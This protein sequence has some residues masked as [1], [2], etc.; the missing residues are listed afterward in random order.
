MAATDYTVPSWRTDLQNAGKKYGGKLADAFTE[1][2][3]TPIGKIATAAASGPMTAGMTAGVGAIK[4]AYNTL[5]PDPLY[6]GPA[7]YLNGKKPATGTPAP[8]AED[9]LSGQT[10]TGQITQPVEAPK[11][12]ARPDA[13][14]GT[15]QTATPSMPSPIQAQTLAAPAH[16]QVQ[17]PTPG[18]RAPQDVT[19]NVSQSAATP[20]GMMIAGRLAMADINNQKR[21]AKTQFNQNMDVAKTGLQQEANDRQANISTFQ[22]NTSAQNNAAHNN[23]TLAQLAQQ[24]PL[25]QAQAGMYG[26]QAAEAKVKAGQIQQLADL[27]GKYMSE[28]DPAKQQALAKNIAILSGK[29]AEPAPSLHSISYQVGS[30]VDPLTGAET[31]IM[32]NGLYDARTGKMIDPGNAVKPKGPSPSPEHITRLKSSPDKNTKAQFDA[33]FGPGAADKIL[34]AK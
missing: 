24:Q 10:M 15:P 22:A 32:A 31:P 12:I 14:S 8:V 21:D 3:N 20:L 27:Q 19:S 6:T 7:E 33:V 1:A 9:Q 17:M 5:N 30:K 18:A 2:S 16:S 4:S 25:Q 28:T 34:G 11:A 29:S 13:V 23:L 26:A